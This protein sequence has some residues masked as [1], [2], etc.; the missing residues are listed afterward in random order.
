MSESRRRASPVMSTEWVS[1]GS[2]SSESANPD[3]AGQASTVGEPASAPPAIAEPSEAD[4]PEP[5]GRPAKPHWWSIQAPPPAGPISARRAYLEVLGVFIAFFAAGI[6]AG[7]ET[8]A[9]RYPPPSGSW[10]V[11]TPPTIGE[12]AM[13][14]LAVT[15]TVL[16]SIRRGITP[17]K[18]GLGLPRR[19]DGGV[20]VAPS[21]RMAVWAIVTLSVGGVIISAL[22][23]GHLSQP[24]VQD[25]SYLM[26]TTAASLAAGV[27]EETVVLAFVVTTLRQAGRPLAE[28]LAVAVLLRCSYHD[29]YGFGV[30]GIAIW[31]AVFV[32]LYLRTGSVLPMMIVHVLWDGAIFL[33]YWSVLVKDAQAASFVL[34]PLV[35]AGT[36]IAGRRRRT[37]QASVDGPL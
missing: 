9:R 23:T 16:L 30:V 32:W 21:F 29:Y 18:L 22:A 15:V 14:G 6:V 19:A 17:R 36:W 27:V 20:A 10:A 13:A 25:N 1:A 2:A 33:S 26:Y 12:L 4:W 8:L 35:A 34:I 37:R 24:I 3:P 5:I 7:G 31:A 28:I 11:F